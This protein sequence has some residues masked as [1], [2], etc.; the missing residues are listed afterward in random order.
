MPRPL[1]ALVDVP[2]AARFASKRWIQSAGPLAGA[3]AARLI[4]AK[5][6]RLA[7]FAMEG[8]V[9]LEEAEELLVEVIRWLHLAALDDTGTDAFGVPIT[10]PDGSD[11]GEKTMEAGGHLAVLLLAARGRIRLARLDVITVAEL[12]ALADYSVDS[13]SKAAGSQT[14]GARV[15]SVGYPH[16]AEG[17]KLERAGESKSRKFPAPITG[18]S[19]RALLAMNEVPGFQVKRREGR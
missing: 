12:G 6:A 14:L 7:S 1:L 19:A 16:G 11:D 3:G 18:A 17:V 13:I 15:V 10:L 4:E 8:A 5:I 9:E 2:A